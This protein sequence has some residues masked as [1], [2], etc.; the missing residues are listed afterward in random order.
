[1]SFNFA[2]TLNEV[3]EEELK[4]ILW[5][6]FVENFEDKAGLISSIE[7][8]LNWMLEA[9][10]EDERTPHTKQRV[11]VCETLLKRL[12]KYDDDGVI[13]KEST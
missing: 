5:L 12:D 7:D 11:L 9:I 4:D 8:N 2:S 1:M 3:E 13:T 6:Y 10:E